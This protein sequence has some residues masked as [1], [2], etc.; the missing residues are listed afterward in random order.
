MFGESLKRLP[1]DIKEGFE[2]QILILL[3]RPS[4]PHKPPLALEL[5]RVSCSISFSCTVGM[6][7]K[8]AFVLAR[9]IATNV[10]I[11]LV[12]PL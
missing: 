2:A 8:S 6:S 11:D 1:C 7:P 12:F 4:L 10:H 9:V 3:L 5:T